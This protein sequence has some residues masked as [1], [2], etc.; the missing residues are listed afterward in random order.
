VLLAL[1]LSF[2][3]RHSNNQSVAAKP[4]I[5]AKVAAAS[6]GMTALADSNGATEISHQEIGRQKETQN[7]LSEVKREPPVAVPAN[8]EKK[9]AAAQQLPQTNLQAAGSAQVT[10]AK[11]ATSHS[12]DFVAHDTVTYLDGRY[13]PAQNANSVNSGRGAPNKHNGATAANSV[14]YLDEKPVAKP[15]K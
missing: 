6:I 7:D 12:D 13:K 2:G 9:P 10:S 11:I 3:V 4:V 1:A 5:P 8:S 15:A 14:T